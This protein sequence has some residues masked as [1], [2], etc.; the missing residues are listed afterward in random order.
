MSKYNNAINSDSLEYL[1]SMINSTN[2]IVDLEVKGKW[3]VAYLSSG[4]KFS[5]IN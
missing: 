1:K 2:L 3:L 5:V 4:V